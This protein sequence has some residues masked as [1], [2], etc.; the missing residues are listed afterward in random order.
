MKKNICEIWIKGQP[1]FFEATAEQV[2]ELKA[3]PTFSAWQVF[4]EYTTEIAQN[5]IR[6]I[7][8]LSDYKTIYGLIK[9]GLMI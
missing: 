5:Y 3:L 1:F 2:S 9:N 8:N 6:K 4:E 7:A